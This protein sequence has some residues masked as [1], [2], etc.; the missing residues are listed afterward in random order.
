MILHKFKKMTCGNLCIFLNFELIIPEQYNQSMTTAAADV[1]W[2]VKVLI[3]GPLVF[4]FLGCRSPSI[5][6]TLSSK[7]WVPLFVLRHL[8]FLFLC[9]F[10]FFFFA[11]WIFCPK[12]VVIPFS[13]RHPFPC[14]LRV[15][16]MKVS[17]VSLSHKSSTL[18]KVPLACRFFY[19]ADF[20]FSF[21]LKLYLLL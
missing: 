6:I 13:A 4:F 14:R 7:K 11:H 9:F 12:T 8:L 20:F 1:R 17:H 3:S 5:Y 19:D 21:S 16:F 15:H 18:E 10:F 2:A